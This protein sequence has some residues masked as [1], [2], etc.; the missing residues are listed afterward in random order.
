MPPAAT[1]CCPRN[2]GGTPQ[3]AGSGSRPIQRRL[4]SAPAQE[5]PFP[6]L[7]HTATLSTSRNVGP[8]T[9]HPQN[10]NS[11]LEPLHNGSIACLG[12]C[13]E[14]WGPTHTQRGDSGRWRSQQL[15]HDPHSQPPE[16]PRF[17]GN[18]PQRAISSRPKLGKASCLFFF[19]TFTRFFTAFQP[20]GNPPWTFA[21]AVWVCADGV[22]A[23]QCP[24]PKILGTPARGTQS[25]ETGIIFPSQ[26]AFSQ[27]ACLFFS[28]PILTPRHLSH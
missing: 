18:V 2:L 10:D 5:R 7:L 20:G 22:P 26:F 6:Q 1:I 24:L 12:P 25:L 11:G 28:L 19:T 3:M 27:L 4:A 17:T 8:G 13:P 14:D 23:W 21:M 9:G 15:V 16:V